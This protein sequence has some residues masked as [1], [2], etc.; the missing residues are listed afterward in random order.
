M[1]TLA[2]VRRLEDGSISVTTDGEGTLVFD[3]VAAAEAEYRPYAITSGQLSELE[4]KAETM[5]LSNSEGETFSRGLVANE[6]LGAL[7]GLK[8]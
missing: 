5:T 7:D 6:V 4:L 3:S 8:V 2:T 1:G